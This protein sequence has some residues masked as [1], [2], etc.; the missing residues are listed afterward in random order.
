MAIKKKIEKKPKKPSLSEDDDDEEEAIEEKDVD[1][2]NPEEEVKKLKR[3]LTSETIELDKVELKGNKPI[4][5]IKKG[6]KIKVDGI[7]FE[8]DA[9]YVLIDHG[10]TKEMTIEIFNPKT[11]KD[12]QLRYFSDRAETSMEFYE[13]LEILYSKR[14]I[15]KLEW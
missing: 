8:V 4:A 10:K 9:H 7:E 14:P 12:F 5:Q 3:V 1:I 2:G 11:D 6:D 15:K 13:L